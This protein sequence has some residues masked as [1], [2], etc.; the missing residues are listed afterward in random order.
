MN[1]FNCLFIFGFFLIIVFCFL[2]FLRPNLNGNVFLLFPPK[3]GSYVLPLHWLG[4]PVSLL[5]PKRNPP[6]ESSTAIPSTTTRLP[7]PSKKPEIP[8][9]HQ[10]RIVPILNRSSPPVPAAATSWTA[11]TPHVSNPFFLT[12]SVGN[13]AFPQ[14]YP[15]YFQ[16]NHGVS[17]LP[18]PPPP[19][20]APVVTTTPPADTTQSKPPP[21]DP[22]A[23][24]YQFP[25]P[26]YSNVYPWQLPNPQS[27]VQFQFPV[28]SPY[29]IPMPSYNYPPAAP[30]QVASQMPVKQEDRARSPSS[31]VM[32]PNWQLFQMPGQSPGK[33]VKYQRNAFPEN[34]GFQG[35]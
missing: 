13:L 26:P 8:Q 23:Q 5:C 11:K 3:G 10:Y 32:H 2:F 22:V 15:Y 31:Y 19:T 17:F 29:P 24:I 12:N 25:F 27:T 4:T 28:Y 30:P 9:N 21:A 20:A 16:M 33:N 14:P 7:P 34:S 18:P 35:K 6:Q 1:L